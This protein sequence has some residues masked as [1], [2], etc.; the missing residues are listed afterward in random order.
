[1]SIDKQ[2]L[3][4]LNIKEMNIDSLN[5]LATSLREKIVNV[6]EQNGGHLSS[7]LGIV[8]T[9][10]ALHK[11]F[12]F[13]SDKLIFDVGHQCYTHKLLSGRDSQFD[14]L[15]KEGG[16]SGF[17]DIEESKFDA[18]ST[19]HAG[20]SMSAGLGY[21]NARDLQ[22]ED[23][24]VINVIGDGAFV[25]GLN[26]EALSA[27]LTK[28]K[29]YIV[30]LNDNGMSISKNGNGLYRIISKSTTKKG[31]VKSKGA[32]KK[33]F[34]SSFIT[35]GLSR[36]RD[37]LKGILN[38]NNYLER[39]GFKYVGIVDGNNLKSMVKI[40]E[41]VKEVAKN[42]AVFLHIKT[43]KG[44]GHKEAEER[45]DL[46]HGV[47]KNLSVKSG[48]FSDALGGAVNSLIE[49]DN[50]IVAITA[51]MKD[52]TGLSVVEQN[53]PKNFFDVGIAEEYAVTLSAGMAAG[54][55]KPIVAIYSTFMQ[56]AYDQ[57][58]HD[59]CIQKLPV[60][61]CL[62]RA[63]F[64]GE[65][66]KTHQGLFDLSYL[67]HIPNL[68]ILAPASYAELKSAL[69]YAISLN[70]PVAIRY[71]KNGEVEN[72]PNMPFGDGWEV[73]KMGKKINILAVGANMLNL[74]L[75]FSK[76]YEKEKIGVISAKIIK[77]L[78][79]KRLN[80]IAGSLVITLEENSLIGGFGSL[81]RDFYSNIGGKTKVITLGVNNQFVSHG[82]IDSQLKQNMLSIEGI[83]K[84]ISKFYKL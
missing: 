2:S 20:T 29:N 17:P 23:Y 68:T 46:Y 53:H 18:F 36:F 35:K 67:S 32:V 16:L 44:K 39:F 52:G 13:P 41:R 21:C 1:M 12:N 54:G 5:T 49:K 3:K 24:T 72:Y 28:P 10:I 8:E 14:S 61:F 22:G 48:S 63:G 77:P 76:K 66:G 84:A 25:N 60:V 7:N 83:E 56:R 75:E 42:K 27:T 45:S 58:L 80:E 82:T 74:A 9:T 34:G 31:Y 6:V 38:K 19:G 64:V 37:F 4:N 81:V 11:V 79:N 70:S 65:D 40:L 50:K 30:I 33:I 15:R 71:S 59:V 69:K 78:D 55:L 62:D 26:L 51:G 43:Q 57:I 47:G 73:V